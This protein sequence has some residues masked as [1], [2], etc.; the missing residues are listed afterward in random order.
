[1]IRFIPDSWVE[2]VLRPLLLADPAANLYAEIHAPDWR[3]AALAVLALI[4]WIGSRRLAWL[5]GVQGRALIGLVA[6]FYVWT[7]ASG[8]GRYFLWALLLVGPMIVVAVQQLPA[9]RAMRNTILVGVLALQGVSAWLTFEPNLWGLRLWRSGPGLAL[10]ASPV[11]ERPAVFLTI[12]TITY[13]VLVPQLHP[14]SRWSNI[15]GQQELVPGMREHAMLQQILDGPLPKYVVVR[16][17]RLV[18]QDDAQPIAQAKSIV[19]TALARQRLALT[20][21]PCIFL[22]ADVAG[23]PFNIA[24]SKPKVDGF[25]FCPVTRTTIAPTRVEPAWVDP[26]MEAVFERIE[27]RCPR[28]FPP[29]TAKTRPHE[30]GWVRYYV[31]S[32]I[33]LFV[34]HADYVYFKHFRA[35]NPS[36]VGHVSEVLSGA[37]E[38]ECRRP[39]GRYAPPWERD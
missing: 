5:S 38:V 30:D 4:A 20:G 31:Q 36:V 23:T 3:F 27:R 24:G 35:M 21:E 7:L 16:A 8:N 18:M 28:F 1:M 25:W 15:S 29:G 22:R 2:V 37:F 34:N 39:P 17:T 32:D 33:G 6:C 19:A 11:R 10:E 13:S 12:G 9:T 26:H 14:E